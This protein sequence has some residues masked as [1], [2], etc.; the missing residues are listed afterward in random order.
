MGINALPSYKIKPVILSDKT[1]FISPGPLPSRRNFRERVDTSPIQIFTDGSRIKGK[2]GY[3]YVICEHKEGRNVMLSQGRGFLGESTTVFQAEIFAII[4][5]IDNLRI[6]QPTQPFNPFKDSA[7]SI[8][9]DSQASIKALQK[10]PITSALLLNC[11][12]NLHSIA[13]QRP[14]K[15][16][17][18]M[19]HC[20]ISGKEAADLEAKTLF[21]RFVVWSHGFPLCMVSSKGLL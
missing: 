7:V 21:C 10:T 20:G 9:C 2:S 16:Q 1:S 14:L 13:K 3:G 4:K 8:F 19:A 12:I 18:V 11:L 5:A 17:W 15:L 6:L